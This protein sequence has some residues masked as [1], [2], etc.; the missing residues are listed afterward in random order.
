[1]TFLTGIWTKLA[2]AGAILLTV[3]AVI[4]RIF[5]AGRKAERGDN[6]EKAQQNE[7]VRVQTDAG[8]AA[9]GDAE[10]G[11]MRDKWTRR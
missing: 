11:R 1:M 7:R 9:A 3:L 4:A 8:V 10:L 2:A 5:N 6:A